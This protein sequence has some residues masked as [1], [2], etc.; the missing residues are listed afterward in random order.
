VTSCS[1]SAKDHKV[2][3]PETPMEWAFLPIRQPSGSVH[4]RANPI[5]SEHLT[6]AGAQSGMC[7]GG[8]PY[9]NT[10]RI[11]I[12]ERVQVAPVAGVSWSG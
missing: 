8:G 12:R 7:D 4:I 11:S 6:G 9:W 5:R 2:R 1:Q 3:R 10:K